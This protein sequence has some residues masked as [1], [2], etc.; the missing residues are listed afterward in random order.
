MNV[1]LELRHT[2]IVHVIIQTRR[3]GKEGGEQV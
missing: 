3:V 2:A 1:H